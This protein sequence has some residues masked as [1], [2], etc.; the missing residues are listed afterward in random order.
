MLPVLAAVCVLLATADAQAQ[1]IEVF[2]SPV[3]LKPS[4]PDLTRAGALTYTGGLVLTSPDDRFGGF[5]G[6][7]ASRDGTSLIAVSDRGYLLQ[8]GVT[9]DSDG[10]L[11]GIADAALAPINDEDGAPVSGKRN[12]D[13]ESLASAP[14]GGLLIAFERR[15]RIDAYQRLDSPARPMTVPP[16]FPLMPSNHGVE[17]L[18]ELADGRLLALS[19]GFQTDKGLMGWLGTPGKGGAFNWETLA[20]PYDGSFA[21][22]GAATLPDGDILVLERSYGLL[23]GV[24]MRL[25][26]IPARQ[27]NPG[28]LL[29]SP[30]L[31]DMA[32]PF[33]VDNF[34]GVAVFRDPAGRLR[35]VLISDDNYSFLQRTLLLSFALDEVAH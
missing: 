15:H 4:E 34:E 35:I 10:W 23:E 8:L 3:D 2:A 14:D 24:R 17:A 28:S 30:I 11:N 27:M 5:S 25:R 19:E 18:T 7:L 16:Q 21:P 22:S 33:S 29:A 9:F 13:A 20:Y 32:E 31:A 1:P 6:L 12:S 26:R